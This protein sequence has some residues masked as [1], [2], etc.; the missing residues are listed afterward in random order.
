MVDKNYKGENTSPHCSLKED[1]VRQKIDFIISE[2]KKIKLNKEQENYVCSREKISKVLSVGD[3]F[4]Y[5]IM[6]A[7]NNIGF[8]MLKKFGEGKYF[9]WDYSIDK[10]YQ[11]QKYGTKALI[12][13]IQYMKEKHS[14]K[15]MTTTYTYG[16]LAARILYSRIGFLES[17]VVYENG[18]HEINMIYKV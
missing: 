12:E 17:S 5:D 13:L 10:I 7:K 3:A 6:V 2:E 15:V 9:L 1:D 4:A 11:K 14:L 18:I 16:N 8:V